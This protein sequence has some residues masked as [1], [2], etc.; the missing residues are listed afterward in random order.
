MDYTCSV[1]INVFCRISEK[2]IRLL[3]VYVVYGITNV[4]SFLDKLVLTIRSCGARAFVSFPILISHM[5][6]IRAHKHRFSRF[7]FRL[8]RLFLSW[9]LFVFSL[10]ILALPHEGKKPYTSA[11][12]LFRSFVGLQTN[13]S[14]FVMLFFVVVC[15]SVL[16]CLFRLFAEKE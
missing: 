9:L 15:I 16:L 2:L 5:L 8:Q 12:F 6:F 3:Y 10:Y 4:Y 1:R 14:S 7:A 11:T 13:I